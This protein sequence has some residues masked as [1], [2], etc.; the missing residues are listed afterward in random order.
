MNAEVDLSDF[1]MV[2]DDYIETELTNMFGQIIG[3]LTLAIDVF[4]KGAKYY[5]KVVYSVLAE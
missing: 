2:K 5:E 3:S 4:R 1:T